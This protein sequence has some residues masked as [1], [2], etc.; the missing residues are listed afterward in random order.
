MSMSEGEG[1]EGIP[2]L[3]G[4]QAHLASLFHP[5]TWRTTFSSP[6]TLLWRSFLLPLNS[7]VSCLYSGTWE[8]IR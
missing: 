7:G 6:K 8:V 2:L 5:T 1:P 4:P 3:E